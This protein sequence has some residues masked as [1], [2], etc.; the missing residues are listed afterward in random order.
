VGWEIQSEKENLMKRKVKSEFQTNE[1]ESRG[2]RAKQSNLKWKNET[3]T[4]IESDHWSVIVLLRKNI[5]YRSTNGLAFLSHLD[6]QCTL[7]SVEGVQGGCVKR[8]VSLPP[9]NKTASQAN[10]PRIPFL[11]LSLLSPPSWLVSHWSHTQGITERCTVEC[12]QCCRCTHALS[13]S[14]SLNL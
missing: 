14:L 7:D 2:E 5:L 9:I 1:V 11:P 12:L 8:I 4:I 3:T 10:L 13:L 6:R